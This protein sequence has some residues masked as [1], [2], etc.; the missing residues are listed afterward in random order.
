MTRLLGPKCKLCRREGVK[1]FLK[2]ERCYSDKCPFA[3]EGVLPPGQH[4]SR[5]KRRLS[6]YGLQLREKQKVK[7]I[8]GV[9]EN[10]LRNYYQKASQSKKET[11][12]RLLQLLSTR[13]DN[14]VFESGLVESRSL[15]RQLISHGFCLINGKKVNIPSYQVKQKEVISFNIKGLKL[16]PVIEA[17]KKKK[18]EP[19]WLKKKAA[20]VKM[21][22][23]PERE[24]IATD[25]DEKLII[26]FYSR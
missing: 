10:V 20:V 15:A 25:I 5:R 4:G 12:K 9:S 3:K 6:N 18:K 16:K 24:E 1:L 14:I 22:R 7:R 19:L 11:G 2:G 23:L 13:L 17:L 8:Y 26:E 21:E